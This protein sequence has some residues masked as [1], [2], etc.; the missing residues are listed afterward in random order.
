MKTFK[1]VLSFMFAVMLIL[2]VSNGIFSVS[3]EDE[4]EP[5]DAYVLHHNVPDNGYTG[6][7]FQYFSPY[8]TDYTYDG[9]PSFIQNYIY[10][11][12]NT[13]TGEVVPTYCTDIKVGA[14]PDHR[15]RRLNLEDSTYAAG[16]AGQLRTIIRHGFYLENIPGESTA[17]HEARVNAKLTEIGN[18]CGVP[19]LTIGEA[20]SGTQ[21][22]IWQAAH[23]S[24]LEFTDFVRTIYTTKLPTVTRY[25]DLCNAERDN[26]H[27]D[28]SVSAYGQVTLSEESDAYLNAR[29][30]AVYDY[31]LSLAPIPASQKAVSPSSFEQ[32]GE[33]TVE[34]NG[35]GTYDVSITTTVD[36]LMSND[37]YLTLSAS[38]NNDQ[39]ISSTS[40]K[41]GE[42]TVALT[43]ENVPENHANDDV[44]LTIEGMQTAYD[45]YLYD[46]YGGRDTAQSMIGM[47]GSQLPVR[48]RVVSTTDRRLNF[49]K[50][51]IVATGD[52]EF[53]RR[54]LEGITFDIYFIATLEDYAENIRELPD[55]DS[56]DFSKM[57]D[58]S[59]ITDEEGRANVN[60]TQHGLPDGI[61]LVAERSH[62]AIKEPVKP[63][64]VFMP[65]T[66][67]TGDGYEYEIT[68]QPKN[69]VKGE[70]KV[71]KDINSIGNNEAASD[72]Y[73]R[74]TWIV[75]TNIPEDIA[76]GKSFTISD[77]LDNRL[78]YLGD[79]RVTVESLDGET[80]I[81]TLT[82]NVDFTVTVHDV[83]SL[84]EGN[85]SDS[86]VVAL[87]RAGMAKVGTSVNE[88][89]TDYMLRVRFDSQI[90]ANADV[91]VEIPNQA[92]VK[93]TNS[94][95]FDFTAESDKP[96]VST[97]GGNISKVDSR[98]PNKLLEGAI[99]EIYRRATADEVTAGGDNLVTLEGMAGSF[100]KVS[101]FDNPE[102]KGEKV[103]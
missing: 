95:N 24:I 16:A 66:N 70:I 51:T 18:A 30:K 59:V 63:F 13:I 6:P 53:L 33:P 78:D 28:Y 40:L 71:D 79:M 3:A 102:L 42:Q 10:T 32:L 1:R 54:P 25:Y 91:A 73:S 74:H 86:F 9:T 26:G 75:G 38:I 56:F 19:D 34:D 27:I 46:A 88:N 82:E 36:V 15:Y 52:N 20:I 97:G 29:I 92:L 39:Y 58:H 12:Y 77:T 69:D 4:V 55:I 72:A 8:V 5:L 35:D 62:P 103:T 41:N 43:I 68:V 87:T 50:T 60:F 14:L 17:A 96:V 47:D 64:F 98:D 22:A 81:A 65:T 80:V 44:Y 45:V 31:L 21:S 84:S 2:S 99:F 7:R 11:L 76:N 93:Y 90:N 48:A 83:D 100:V 89:F 37:D 101:F 67:A 61:Y 57:A 23:G 49:Y 94:V 85:P